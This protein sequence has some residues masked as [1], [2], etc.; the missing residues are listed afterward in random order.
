MATRRILENLGP[1]TGIEPAKAT[2]QEWRSTNASFTGSRVVPVSVSCRLTKLSYHVA[3]W[4][5]LQAGADPI[6]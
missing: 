3:G 2:L 4:Y 5:V 1:V 6:A